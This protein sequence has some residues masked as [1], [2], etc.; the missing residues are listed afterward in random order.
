MAIEPESSDSRSP[1]WNW[2]VVSRRGAARSG[3]RTRAAG[4]AEPG[5]LL[6]FRGMSG[7]AAAGVPIRSGREPTPGLVATDALRGPS[8]GAGTSPNIPLTSWNAFNGARRLWHVN[9]ILRTPCGP[10]PGRQPLFVV[11][12]WAL[13][14][15]EKHY[16]CGRSE[17]STA[18]NRIFAPGERLK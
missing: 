2:R 10:L 17:T 1:T 5:P 12:W 9:S 14:L 7:G 4:R 18:P 13:R 3:A 16:L 15:S 6:K 8:G 11:A